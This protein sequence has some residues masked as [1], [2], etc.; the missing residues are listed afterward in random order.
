MKDPTLGG[1]LPPLS[2]STK[3]QMRN[4]IDRDVEY[5]ASLETQKKDM[6]ARMQTWRATLKPAWWEHDTRLPKAR[7]EPGLDLVW[8]VDKRR[9]RMTKRKHG[10][11]MAY[12]L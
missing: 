12:K 1:L 3:S 9:E 4:W 6:S 11:G 5:A 7:R 8:P 10:K 2:D